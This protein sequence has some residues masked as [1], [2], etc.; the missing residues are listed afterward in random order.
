MKPLLSVVVPAYNEEALIETTER[1]ISEILDNANIS[2]ELIFVND[3]SSDQT[4][5]KINKTQID[6]PAVNGICFSRNFGKEAAIFAGMQYSK[7]DCCV[8]IDCDLQHPP[9]LIVQMYQLWENGYEV[10]EAVKADRGKESVIHSLAARCF[11]H[12]I[13]KAVNIDLE[14]SSDYKLLDRK[15]V[16]VLLRM[17]EKNTFFRAMSSWIGFRSTQ[18]EFCVQERAAGESK[19]SAISLIKYAVSNISA[20]SAAPMTVIAFLGVLMFCISILLG[21]ITLYDKL[22]GV[23]LEGIPTVI[24]IQLFMGS[25][26]MIS[27]GVIGY[28]IAKIYDEIKGRPRY[29][30]SAICGNRKEMQQR[31]E[32]SSCSRNNV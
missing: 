24:I 7:G 23:S 4:W 8:I 26:I 16:D 21:C 28:Y 17:P 15:A 12:I 30:I 18:I 1:T 29:I 13:S 14:R 5:E 27:L 22:S 25:I 19:W 32:C 10:V 2:Y 3:G 31:R 11:Y 9:E 20:F 6:N